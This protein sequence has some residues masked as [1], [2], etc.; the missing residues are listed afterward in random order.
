MNKFII[1]LLVFGASAIALYYI[2]GTDTEQM[3]YLPEDMQQD[4]LVEDASLEDVER[5]LEEDG[6][7]TVYG[8]CNAI[9][10][11]STCIEYIGSV[12]GEDNSGKLNCSDAGVFSENPCPQPSLGG[13]QTG[14]GTVTE[15]IAWMYKE[16]G[17][18]IDAE[19]IP[20]A[21]MACEANPLGN[22]LK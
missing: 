22:W 5:A 16:G 15:M 3:T 6:P 9:A 1:A 14:G 2:F 20:Y 19:S 18:E 10:E 12:W 17:G 11:S 7:R 13:C 21:E 4:V 8:S